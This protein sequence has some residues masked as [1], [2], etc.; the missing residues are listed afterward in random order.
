MELINQTSINDLNTEDIIMEE[1]NMTSNDTDYT[2]PLE[3]ND[4]NFHDSPSVLV[5]TASF[6]NETTWDNVNQIYSSGPS[7]IQLGGLGSMSDGSITYSINKDANKGRTNGINAVAHHSSQI[8]TTNE[9]SHVSSTDF[10]DIQTDG[11]DARQ[12]R[13]T[14]EKEGVMFSLSSRSSDSVKMEESNL[15]DAGDISPGYSR[16]EADMRNFAEVE[17]LS[18]CQSCRESREGF[19]L[20]LQPSSVPQSI[21]RK[22]YARQCILAAYSSRL[23]PYAL[24]SGEFR[25]FRGQITRSQVT[26]YLNIRNA[27]LRLWTR[28]P[29]LSV[30][31]QE[32]LGCARDRRHLKLARTAYDWLVRSGYVNFGCVEN[33][34]E[35]P[36]IKHFSIK[37]SKQ[38]TV[39]VVGAGMAGLGCARQ[40]K[41][42]FACYAMR[43]AMK[44]EKSPRIIVIEGRNRIG[45]RIYSHP[46]RKQ[47]PVKS[48]K[49]FRATAEMGAQIIT[50]FD[51]G[52]PLNA[53][54]RGQLALPY[55]SIRDDSILFDFD[56]THVDKKR[57]SSIEKLYNDMLDKVSVYRHK[58]DQES[59][60][61]GE[62]RYIDMSKDPHNDEGPRLG[63]LYTNS[64]VIVKRLEIKNG[65]PETNE[66]SST[67]A[68][69]NLNSTYTEKADY[70]RSFHTHVDKLPYGQVKL[71]AAKD[72]PISLDNI[73]GKSQV[74]LGEV[75]DEAIRQYQRNAN[76]STQDL[77][78]LNWHNANLEYA[79]AAN[80]NQLSLGGW[81]QDIGNEFEGEHTEII[82]GYLQVLRGLWKY[83]TELD[84]RFKHKVNKVICR[85]SDNVDQKPVS[86][87]CSNGSTI[88]ADQV[89]M[90][91]PLGVLKAGDIN[92]E[93]SLPVWKNDC[94]QRIGFGLLNK[95]FSTRHNGVA[96]LTMLDYSR[97][98]GGV[99]EIR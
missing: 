22:E 8:S 78:L 53:I 44:D 91:T 30:S 56:G 79:N 3:N 95:V 19:E 41:G 49:G 27:I 1:T 39:V 34:E 33:S 63:I 86:L 98:Q 81:D 43:F 37:P 21:P 54:I 48:L 70:V 50:G 59:T 25:L 36:S 72:V 73:A 89:I 97:L 17:A 28:N 7:P 64:D 14:A 45:G 80:I 60:I 5:D 84:I 87:V 99:L 23:N 2:H 46:L 52:N 40:L 29:L 69:T 71:D 16:F 61:E 93:P 58:F 75:M 83:P 96:R 4:I 20:D 38:R 88:E 12:S 92:F 11:T 85:E 47:A 10:V 18:G 24:H 74:T 90:T 42:L 94:I 68:E 67:R 31:V 65:S 15:T 76:L 32:A 9:L 55:H 77:R 35:F 51:S 57:D 26:V 62:R 82:G 13:Q 6:A 66:T